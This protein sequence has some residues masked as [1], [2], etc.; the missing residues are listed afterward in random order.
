[1]GVQGTIGTLVCLAGVLWI[2]RNENVPHDSRVSGR[3]EFAELHAVVPVC[4]AVGVAGARYRR[5]VGG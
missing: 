3:G 4:D 1:V 5:G 2:L